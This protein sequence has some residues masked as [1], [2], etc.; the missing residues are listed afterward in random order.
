[1]QGIQSYVFYVFSCA[2]AAVH[3]GSRGAI[4]RLSSQGKTNSEPLGRAMAMDLDYVVKSL[5][6]YGA[7]KAGKYKR[8]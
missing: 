3:V 4:G 1:M 6:K 7:P 8:I 5:L 2:S